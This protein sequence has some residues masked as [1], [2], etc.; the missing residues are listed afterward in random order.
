MTMVYPKQLVLN[1][2]IDAKV[3]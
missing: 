1:F 2:Y 3:M